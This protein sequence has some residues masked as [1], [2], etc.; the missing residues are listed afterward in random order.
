MKCPLKRYEK[1]LKNKEIIRDSDFVRINN[2][3]KEE[4]EESFKYAKA[5]LLPSSD[6]L[7]DH[8]YA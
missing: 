1:Y 4:I 6:A 5:S 3:I 2:N 7:F 8:F